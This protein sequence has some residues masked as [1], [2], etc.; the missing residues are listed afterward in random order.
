MSE[1]KMYFHRVVLLFLTSF[2]V[3]FT[4]ADA[5]RHETITGKAAFADYSQQKPGVFRKIT[6]ADLPPPF[7][8]E[9]VANFPSVVSRPPN[10]WPQAPPGFKVELYAAG[11]NYP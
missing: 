6:V 9:S 1:R 3:A 11:L 5:G 10:A 7:A 4:A 8:S 2:L